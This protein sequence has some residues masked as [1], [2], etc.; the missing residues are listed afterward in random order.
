MRKSINV[1]CVP[2]IA[3]LGKKFSFSSYPLPI[4]TILQ[5]YHLG[6][7]EAH[8]LCRQ[9]RYFVSINLLVVKLG[10]IHNSEMKQIFAYPNLALNNRINMSRTPKPLSPSYHTSS[11]D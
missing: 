5:I 10:Q 11:Q 9:A 6:P 2:K 7:S 8:R 1:F 3:P 4:S